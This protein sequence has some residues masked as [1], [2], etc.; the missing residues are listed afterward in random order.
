MV[1]EK[2]RNILAALA[3]TP[4]M[5]IDDMAAVHGWGHS[6]LR[7]QIAR[8]ERMEWVSRA[9]HSL[10]GRKAHYRYELTREGV[11]ALAD[12][13]GRRTAD[14]MHRPGATGYGL[15]LFR[16]RLDILAGVYKV[17]GSVARASDG[18]GLRIHLLGGDLLDAA[19]RIPR[20]PYSLGVMVNRPSFSPRSWSKRLWAYDN[21]LERPAGLLVVS[22]DRM[23]DY[24]VARLVARN[25]EGLAAIAPIEMID[26][27]EERVWRQP[28]WYDHETL[29][30]VSILAG[31]PDELARDFEP[32]QQIYRRAAL[33]PAKRDTGSAL[34]R[35]ERAALQVISDWPLA[36]NGLVVALTELGP[37]T[38][39]AMLTRLRS[40]GLIRSVLVNGQTR[41]ALTDAGIRHIC[42]AARA[43]YGQTRR[44]WSSERNDD[45]QMVGTRLRKL[46]RE[47]QHTDM[48]YDL[49]AEFARAASASIDVLQ[50]RITPA[51][52]SEQHFRHDSIS[53][54]IHHVL[55][56]ATVH[57]ETTRGTFVLLLESERGWVWRG[58]MEKRLE[59]YARYFRTERPG[60]D[61]PAWPR[62]AVVF[63]DPGAEA[64]F[65]AAQVRAGLDY[66]P[67]IISNLHDMKAG[68]GPVGPVWRR[69]GTYETRQPFWEL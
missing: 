18:P 54:A 25:Y 53:R 17:A 57:M 60:E 4:F 35:A 39:P 24:G 33:P 7:R 13:I 59:N 26:D 29:S 47:H 22:P 11:I 67:T 56:D 58:G 10:L 9:P 1:S 30:M 64:N 28:R 50:H 32:D 49:A 48:V 61:Y 51:H 68:G 16:R 6:P 36:N 5:T 20:R 27:P 38:V 12:S 14:V 62:I 15:S 21:E 69:P 37:S 43:D 23:S 40:R 63:E 45:G 46:L 31:I 66:L 44:R 2:V 42:Y 3:D 65:S 19:I 52:L 8:L 34:T 41:Q 55:P